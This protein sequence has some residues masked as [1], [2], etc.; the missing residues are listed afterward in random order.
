MELLKK[1]GKILGYAAFGIFMLA[2]CIFIT[3][4]SAKDIYTSLFPKSEIDEMTV[5]GK[6]V[7]SDLF[8][9]LTFYAAEREEVVNGLTVGAD[10]LVP[11]DAEEY[12]T[13]QN[14]DVVQ[15]VAIQSFRL[16]N[17]IDVDFFVSFLLFIAFS[18][19]ILF[20]LA[21]AIDEVPVIGKKNVFFGTL[22]KRLY[23]VLLVIG[24]SLVYISLGKSI[25]TSIQA[26][27][28][29]QVQ[30]EA[31]ITDYYGDPGYGKYES[32]YY[33]LALNYEDEQ[34]NSI[35]MTK[36]VK[37]SIYYESGDTLMVNY[38]AGEPLKVHF[39]DAGSLDLFFYFE[40]LFMYLMVFVLTGMGIFVAVLMR[41]YKK[42]GSYWKKDKKKE[43]S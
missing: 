40:H 38:P 39:G 34:G 12:K 43:V 17:I 5:E 15:G 4:I 18:F 16:E 35:H 42:T 25:V 2:L 11:I 28:G 19:L 36:Q 30:T 10:G 24:F 1:L 23:F 14:G 26:H 21:A 37:P 27:S 6:A 9:N 31:T 3:V 13:L 32:A 29:E 20:F 33:Y 22:I 41:R 8:G 7:Y